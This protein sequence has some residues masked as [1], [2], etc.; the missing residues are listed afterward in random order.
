MNDVYPSDCF[1]IM[2]KNLDCFMS[3]KIKKGLSQNSNEPSTEDEK[4]HMSYC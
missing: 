1:V 3:Q 2:L 4:D